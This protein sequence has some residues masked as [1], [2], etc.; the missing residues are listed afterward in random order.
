MNDTGSRKP[1]L[2]QRA[3]AGHGAIAL[4]ASA[5][6][7]II[8]LSG[9]LVVVAPRLQRWEQ[10][11]VAEHQP[12]APAA[13][14]AAIAAALAQDAGKPK[15]SHVYVRMST[16][17]FPR[18]TVTTDH[19]AWYVDETGRPVAR[20][21][22]AWTEFLLGLHINLTLPATWGMLL[23][24]SIGVALA[25]VTLT[26]VLALPKIVRD[27]FRLRARHDARIARADWHNRLGTWTLPFALT[28]ALTGGII[29][30][31]SASVALLAR[32]DAGGDM[33]AVYSLIFG[34]EPPENAAPAPLADAARALATLT[35]RQPQVRPTF[36]IVDH[37]GTRGQWIQ[38]LAEHPRRLIYGESYR[39]DAT[40]AYLGKVGLSDG[41]TG[42]QAA[43]SV[44]RLHFGTFAGLP[45]ALGY[46][47][48]GLA[49]CAITATGTTLW[50]CKRE[51]AGHD[52]ARLAAGWA[53]VVWGTPLALLL[54]LWVRWLAG[55]EAPL[56]L[57]FWLSLA[58]ATA[59]AVAWP[60]LA[61]GRVQRL[62]LAAALLIT[63]AAHV[64][65]F[66]PLPGPLVAVDACLAGMA[67]VLAI[68]ARR[69]AGRD[70]RNRQAPAALDPGPIT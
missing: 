61:P 44:Y 64:A 30:L 31:G 43:A 47:A 5:L 8:A 59:A 38:I 20:E 49:M 65:A 7:Y 11:A 60:R 34:D 55:P 25:A 18:T 13:V 54:A 36:V 27:A 21:A 48:M 17:D 70:W 37:P 24:G 53:A 52:S 12:I 50:L 3:L 41:E 14:Q 68:T 39:F 10:P 1:G 56:A 35:A 15:T 58:A 6:I 57:L 45:V 4:L 33:L 63:A 42:R 40:G 19:A 9:T 23:V 46:M 28:V 69:R 51:R 2:A 66:S 32:S 67:A 62:A 16:P 29:G 26:G 22:N